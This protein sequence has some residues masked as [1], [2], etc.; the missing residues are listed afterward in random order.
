MKK[1]I[2]ASGICVLLSGQ[3]INA[4]EHNPTTYNMSKETEQKIG[5]TIFGSA[6]AGLAVGG[7]VGAIVGVIGG[8]IAGKQMEAHEHKDQMSDALV[9]NAKEI[10]RLK[11]QL[12][13]V[14][15]DNQA[16]QLLSIHQLEFQV[17]FNTGKDELNQRGQKKVT[18][19]AE[20]LAQRPELNIR[21]DGFADPRGTDEYNNVLS[22]HRALSVKQALIDAGVAERRISTYSH[23]SNLSTAKNGNIDDY[24]TERRVNIEITPAEMSTANTQP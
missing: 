2:L 1:L 13:N 18:Q 23:G 19:L 12:A 9:A 4:K 7:P 17:L 5:G 14:Q 21:L 16:L 24:A 15:Q 20:Y 11:W 6:L 10:D 8:H 22:Q 3:T